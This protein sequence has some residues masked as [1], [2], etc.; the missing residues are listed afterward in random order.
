M[1]ELKDR[2]IDPDFF[3]GKN[4]SKIRN[5]EIVGKGEVRFLQPDGYEFVLKFR[6]V[7]NVKISNMTLWHSPELGYCKG[8]VLLFRDSKNIRL[9]DLNLFGSGTEGLTLLSVDELVLSDSRIYDCSEQLSTL[10]NSTNVTYDNVRVE[11]NGKGL[12][13]GFAIFKSELLFKNSYIN[14]DQFKFSM[15]LADYDKSYGVY[16]RIDA[17]DFG[18]WHRSVSEI[19]EGTY[20][21]LEESKITFYNTTVNGK[22]IN[23]VIE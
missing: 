2:T 5:V 16:F 21:P 20:S 17:Y 22:L 8:G 12:L 1:P 4:I 7:Q 23:G 9:N 6:N 19:K 13:R 14:E 18:D 11:N 15:K 10:S 3:D